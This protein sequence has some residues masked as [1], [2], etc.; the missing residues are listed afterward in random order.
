MKIIVTGMNGTVAPYAA[1]ALMERGHTVVPWNRQAIPTD[2]AIK[3]REFLLQERADYVLH[4]ALGPEQWA[5]DMAQACFQNGAG[6]LF[7]STVDVLSDKNSGPYT[8]EDEPFSATDYGKYKI[9]CEKMIRSVNPDA[10]IVRLGWQIGREP[11]SNNMVDF[12]SRQMKDNGVI[13]A[14]RDWYPS[15][16]YLWDTAQALLTAMGLP[17]DTYLFNANINMSFYEIVQTLQKDHP[18]FIVEESDGLVRDD[19]MIDMRLP[20]RSPFSR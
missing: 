16:S 20:A 14:G 19:R 5:S 11:G 8:P 15:C 17:P 4:I 3:T 7:T 12:L 13:R 9:R 18:D 2:N 6:F 10:R 1:K